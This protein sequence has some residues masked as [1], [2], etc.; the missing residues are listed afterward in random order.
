[1]SSGVEVVTFGCRLNGVES[2][3]MRREAEAA[4]HRDLVIVNTCAVTGEAVRQA[5]QAIR[6]LRRERPDA[7][8]VVTGCAAEIDPKSFGEA[9]DTLTFVGNRLKTRPATWQG[10]L[11]GPSVDG[12]ASDAAHHFVDASNGLESHTRAFVEVQNGCDHRCTFCVIPLG[13]GPSRSAP[14]A[15]I[16]AQVRRLADNGFAEVVLTGV[17]LTSYGSDQDGSPRLGTLVCRVLADVPGLA[18]LRLSSLD[19]MEADDRL[20]EAM[21]DARFMPHLHLS[22][23]AGDDVILKR[24]KRR[25]SFEDA[26][27]FARKVR[28]LRPDMVLGADVIAGFPTETEAMFQRSLDLVSACGLTHLHVFPYSARPGTPAARMP[29]VDGPTIKERARRL[30][31]AGARSLA[32]HLEAQKGRRLR[33]LGERGGMARAEDFTLVRGSGAAPGAL[34]EVSIAAHDG[35]VLIAA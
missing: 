9:G 24:M 33:V 23:Q 11:G 20:F 12:E 22:L 7:K 19:C 25:H 17:D 29:Q 5:R 35:S 30:R 18:R 31:E 2:D 6:R 1:M 13:R 3:A 21:A 27:A 10:L 15:D 16:L 28:R 32:A 26:V 4:G 34:R 8:I 14:I